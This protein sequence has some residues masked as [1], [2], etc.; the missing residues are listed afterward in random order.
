MKKIHLYVWGTL[1]LLTF[2]S[3]S[4]DKLEPNSSKKEAVKQQSASDQPQAQPAQPPSSCPHAAGN[5]TTR[6]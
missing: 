4:K 6:G 3:C 1:F 2:V 5:T